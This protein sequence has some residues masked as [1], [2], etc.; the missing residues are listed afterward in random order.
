M[1]CDL[2]KRAKA[3]HEEDEEL[4]YAEA[5]LHYTEFES[6]SH[7]KDLTR[8]HGLKLTAESPD[9]HFSWLWVAPDGLTLAAHKAPFE[10][11]D[12][13]LSYTH[14]RGPAGAAERLFI[15]IAATTTYLKGEF[16]PL[17][18][19]CGEVVLSL[20]DLEADQ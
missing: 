18:L 16:S 13:Y 14:I 9:A 6:Y 15:D 4:E 10:G 2:E 5:E 12:G 17:T 8:R 7:F 20:N 3:L 1:S 11:E 19:D